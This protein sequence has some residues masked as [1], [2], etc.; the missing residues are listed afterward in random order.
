MTESFNVVLHS[1][2]AYDFKVEGMALYVCEFFRLDAFE[3]CLIMVT[4]ISEAS[5]KKQLLTSEEGSIVQAAYSVTNCM[6]YMVTSGRSRDRFPMV[7]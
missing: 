1:C 5:E 6:Q 4:Q 2:C 7:S 3:K